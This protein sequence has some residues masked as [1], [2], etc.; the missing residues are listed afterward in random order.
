MTNHEVNTYH[1]I[2]E[3]ITWKRP[4]LSI[5]RIAVNGTEQTH[6]VILP[7]QKTLDIVIEGETLEDMKTD[8]MVFIHSRDGVT[9]ASVANGHYRGSLIQISKGSF[10]LKSR[11]ILP[12]FLSRGW[13][14]LDVCLHHPSY[15]FQMKAPNCVELEVYGSQE[16][17]GKAVYVENYGFCGLETEEVLV[18]QWGHPSQ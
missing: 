8:I 15:E 4:F 16:G 17:F 7:N 12:K 6:S 13:Y 9:M 3:R 10:K 14:Y 2:V 18:E 1:L 5:S 11:I